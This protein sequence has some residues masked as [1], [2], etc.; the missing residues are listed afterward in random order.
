MKPLPGDIVRR[1]TWPPRMYVIVKEVDELGIR[2]QWH[3][4][5]RPQGSPSC[6]FSFHPCG[7]SMPFQIIGVDS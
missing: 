4:L 7:V 5:D 2:G 3:V 6:F 1:S